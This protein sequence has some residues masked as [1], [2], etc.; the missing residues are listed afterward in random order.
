M[1]LTNDRRLHLDASEMKLLLLL[2]PDAQVADVVT[3]EFLREYT[4]RYRATPATHL[5]TSMASSTPKC[6][7]FEG[8]VEEVLRSAES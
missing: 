3:I 1:E 8:Q 5:Y 6:T 4:D 2:L 7:A